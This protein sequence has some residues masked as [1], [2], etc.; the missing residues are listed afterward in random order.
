[1]KRSRPASTSCSRAVALDG[2]ASLTGLLGDVSR[3]QGDR[4]KLLD[5]DNDSD[6]DRRKLLDDDNDSD[7]DRRKL[8]DNDNDSD[9]DRRKL[10]DNDSDGEVRD[11]LR[12][13][14]HSFSLVGA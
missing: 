7:G 6:G 3:A 12:Q 2:V 9:G 11:R 13:C 8:L 4:R 14:E 10:L 1:M 5:N